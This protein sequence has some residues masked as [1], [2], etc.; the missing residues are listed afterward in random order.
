MTEKKKKKKGFWEKLAY[1]ELTTKNDSFNADEAHYLLNEEERKNVKRIKRNAVIKAATAGAMGVILLFIPVHLYSYLS[2]GELFPKTQV[3]IPIYGDYI[4]IQIGYYIYSF[5]LLFLEIWYLTYVNITAVAATAQAC[6]FPDQQD[7]NYE[8]SLNGLIAVG[9]ERKQKEL[10]S[11]GINPYE[12]LTK[13]QV[14][15]YQTVI[16]LKAMLTGFLFKLLIRRVLGRY[17]IRAVVDLAGIPVYA[18][19]NGF[20]TRTILNKARVRIMAPALIKRFTDKIYVEAKGNEVFIKHLFDYLQNISVTKRDYHYNHYLLS[21]SLMQKFEVSAKESPMTRDDL[22]EF[23]EHQDTKTKLLYSKLL[24]FGLM[25]D[26][27]V[28]TRETI[29]LNELRDKKILPYS[30]DQIKDWTKGFFDGEGMENFFDYEANLDD[31]SERSMMD[32]LANKVIQNVDPTKLTG[33]LTKGIGKGVGKGIDGLG[34]G[35]GFL[36][37]KVEKGIKDAIDKVEGKSESESDSE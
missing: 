23:M 10:E 31:T 6:G 30:V 36:K 7:K 32:K 37:N 13:W 27:S 35:A 24:A 2:N 3:W 14:F 4:G 8:A 20:A 33:D 16:R 34:K 9:L 22:F 11:I 5:I 18:F 28:S 25:I 1:K 26:G 21:I 17:A 29:I 19:W 15:L 12:G